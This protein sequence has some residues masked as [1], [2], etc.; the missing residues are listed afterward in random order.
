M[1]CYPTL[2]RSGP[3]FSALLR[4]GGLVSR[5][6]A[7]K[8]RVA[9]K[10]AGTYAALSEPSAGSKTRNPRTDSPASISAMDAE[11]RV[12]VCKMHSPLLYGL[13]GSPPPTESCEGRNTSR[14]ASQGLS[15]EW[16]GYPVWPLLAKLAARHIARE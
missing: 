5:H 13:A 3:E 10:L 11:R 1:L 7:K 2:D 4:A 15:V 9:V 14:R 16:Q 8:H 12:I 6:L